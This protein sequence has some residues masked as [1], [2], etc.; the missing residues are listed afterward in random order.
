ML[1]DDG[2]YNVH[3]ILVR[4]CKGMREKRVEE[5]EGFTLV[6]K[7]AGAG[8]LGLGTPRIELDWIGLD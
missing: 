6:I 4:W 2:I 1:S 5:E 7:A 8:L 3:V